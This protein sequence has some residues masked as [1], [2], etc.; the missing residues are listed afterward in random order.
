MR[1]S[2]PTHVMHIRHVAKGCV[3][4]LAGCCIAAVR[5]G[6]GTPSGPQL[7]A[8]S[9]KKKAEADRLRP[10]SSAR[11]RLQGPTYGFGSLD[12]KS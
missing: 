3:H 4:E 9:G 1:V 7:C 12:R 2:T 5:Y 11:A 8:L 6:R 10:S